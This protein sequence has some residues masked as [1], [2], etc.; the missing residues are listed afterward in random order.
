MNRRFPALTAIFLVMALT[1]AA[2]GHDDHHED[3]F[4]TQIFSDF[5]VDG[6]IAFTPPATFTVSTANNTLSVLAGIAP[7]DA[8]E[9]R[10]FLDFPLGGSGGVP[11]GATII[12]ATLEVFIRR[13]DVTAGANVPIVMDL[14]SFPPPLV[15]GDFNQATT[16][17]L[18]SR[19]VDFF[20]SDQGNF[21]PIDVTAFMQ[22]AQRLN[23]PEFQVR[24]LLSTS[25]VSGRIEIDDQPTVSAT[26][27]LL[28]VE[29]L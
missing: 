5:N 12:S 24:L 23:L 27:P 26:A 10:G 15:A 21:V 6:D 25:V 9:F 19:T 29:Y 13:V 2:C 16:V 8:T 28:T 20:A 1:L 18:L 17:P 14:I 11:S 7:G 22:E 4:T 3:V